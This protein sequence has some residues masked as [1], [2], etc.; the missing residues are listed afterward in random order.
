MKILGTRGEVEEYSAAHKKHSGILVHQV[1]FDCGEK[2]FLD[3]KPKAI[4][5]SHLHPD[6]A[7][8]VKT[9]EEMPQVPI[10]A[11]ELGLK[12]L[13]KKEIDELT[14]TAIPTAHSKKVK[15]AGYLIEYKGKKIF[16]SADMMWILK[17]YFP[18]IKDCDL[19]I[20]EGSSFDRDLIRKDKETGDRYGHK[21]IENLVRFW[22][23]MGAKKIVITHYGKWLIDN[24]EKGYEK[25]R[26]LGAEPAKDG[27][28]I[29]EENLQMTTQDLPEIAK[30]VVG[31]IEEEP[32]A[33]LY[34][35]APHGKWIAD[36]S[37]KIVV[38]S[39]S[40]SAHINQPLYLLEDHLC[41]GII[42]LDLPEEITPAQFE[43][44]RPLHK[45]TDEEAFVHWGWDKKGPLYA[46]RVHRVKIWNEPKKVELPQGI[47]VFVDSQN[48]KFLDKL[49]KEELIADWKSYDPMKLIQTERG[50]RVLADDHRIV[51]TWWKRLSQ[52]KAMKS[53]QF[54]DYSLEE[55]KKIVKDLHDAIVKTFEKLKWKHRTPLGQEVLVA[56]EKID[57]QDLEDV[58]DV[59]C[60][61]LS[62]KQLK[63]LHYRLHWIYHNKLQRTTEP[64]VNAHSFVLKELDKRNI[65]FKEVGDHLDRIS[66]RIIEEYPTPRGFASAESFP[67]LPEQMSETKPEVPID[68]K[69]RDLPLSEVLKSLPELIVLSED[70]VH[71]HFCG[72]L[73]NTGTSPK[74]HDID[75]LFK[76]AFPD[77][78][79]IHQFVE[80]ISKSNPELGRR[81]H[82]VWDPWGP[83]IGF[84]VPLYRLAFKRISE[85][86]MRK[87]SPYEYLAVAQHIE[88]MKPYRMLKP[89]S[90]FHKNEFFDPQEMWDK[91]G[92]EVIEKGLIIQKKYDGMRFQIHV[93]GN[94]VKF[95]TE[96]KL[97]DRADIFKKS[98]KELLEKKTADSFVCDAEM[99]EY[100]CEGKKVKDKEEICTPLK[101]ELMIPWITATK[102]EMDDENIVFHIHDCLYLDGKD[103][104]EEGYI[105][106]WNAI[107]KCFPEGLE[108]FRRVSGFEADNMRQF[109]M[110]VNKTRKIRGSEG[111][112]AKIK[113]SKYKLTGRTA[114]WAK[115]KNLKEID[116]MVW[117]I[118]QK[119][120]KAGQKLNQWIYYPVFQIP[121]DMEK[122]IREGEVIKYEGKCYAK[123]G[124][125]YG[126]AIKCTRGDI[127]TVRPV[128][129]VE[130]KDEKTGKIWW[131]WM[132][133]YFEGKKPEKKE[134]DTIDT[135]RKI[136]RVGTAPLSEQLAAGLIIRLSHCPYWRDPEICPLRERFWVPPEALSNE[137][138]LIQY[139]K[140]PVVCRFANSFRCHFV[141]DYYYD[142]RPLKDDE[143]K[144]G[145]EV[146]KEG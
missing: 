66:E 135:V 104:H 73:T 59:Y 4:F 85:E 128:Q 112:V 91:W 97:R 56:P 98:I 72:R 44:L 64:L 138:V 10:W 18:M 11:P 6:H 111:V 33:G 69:S 95:I 90:G 14:V 48:I 140:F 62:D 120:T 50:E 2:E 8:W 88:A 30:I 20:T 125:A 35:V 141:K 80:D 142:L 5:I 108:H 15:S 45:V 89:Q 36:G 133:P 144:I 87:T 93:K 75:I 39:K 37:K 41:Y 31:K 83:H 126:T 119:T 23:R 122:D 46:Y 16:Y 103:I 21:S 65:R 52:G 121:C 130:N 12:K 63:A 134:P 123:I 55:Q 94:Q 68:E 40:F 146:G 53:P 74:G 99:V 116:V 101:R 105:E 92:A 28:E 49:S 51:H 132:F 24:P 38:K 76:Q 124:R 17:K 34:L 78:R 7:Y 114:D 127:I 1:L 117:D 110:A 58:D 61:A 137:T 54:A 60:S 32:E 139:L 29:N 13:E 107:K 109:F 26:E 43:K 145:E 19:V 67:E 115:L 102:K 77:A 100:N 143:Y 70:P 25:I 81:L 57:I 84:S 79:I 47:Q 3:H 113:D 82:F 42:T 9:K 131:S 129:I 96:D 71:V 86:E 106:R 22:D 27:T 118:Q 136:V